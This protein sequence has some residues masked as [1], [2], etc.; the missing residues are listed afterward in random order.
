MRSFSTEKSV[1]NKN[2]LFE[3]KKC[4]YNT[5]IKSDWMKHLKTKK[6]NFNAVENLFFNCEYCGKNY[7]D[8]SGLWYHVKRCDKKNKFVATEEK[9]DNFEN[10]DMIDKSLIL[11]LLKQNSELQNKIIEISEKIGTN[12][13]YNNN[14]NNKQ[15][16]L[17]FFLNETC[18][19]AMNMADFIDSLEIKSQELEDFGKLGYIKGI[20]N[21]FIRSLKELDET[22]RPLHCTDKKRET[23][24]IKENDIWEK[25]NGNKEK[26]R[27]IIK[28]IVHKNFKRI[29]KW[30]EDNPNS[31]ITSS[32][33]NIE[34]MR[35]L[36]QVMS[37]VTCDD[38]QGINKIIKSVSNEVYLDKN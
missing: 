5:C 35:I 3:C 18:K 33:K 12:N 21:I 37:G 24:Y 23:F 15:F 13:S 29:P 32:N 26:M 28:E 38:E 20:S 4:D 10:M 36:N 25:E 19:N 16:N 22:Q 27:K 7:K 34:Y 2:N 1:S 9:K 8:R 17:Q 6:H 11:Q 30:R 14:C 31:E